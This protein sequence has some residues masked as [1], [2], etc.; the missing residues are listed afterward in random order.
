MEGVRT[1]QDGQDSQ[2]HPV[3]PVHPVFFSHLR[4]SACIRGSTTPAPPHPC[5]SV[6]ICGSRPGTLAVFSIEWRSSDEHGHTYRHRPR[7]AQ[8][9]TDSP[10]ASNAPHYGEAP[11]PNEAKPGKT[12]LKPMD[13]NTLRGSSGPELEQSS[14]I[15]SGPERRGLAPEPAGRRC[16]CPSQGPVAG[17][18]GTNISLTSMRCFSLGTRRA[19]RQ[20]TSFS[21]RR[22]HRQRR[23]RLR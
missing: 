6:F 22:A 23:V 18:G 1:R 19:A 3:D 7:A 9:S 15:C 21:Q 13:N 2:D 10:Y 4:P 5:P 12:A 16:Q 8:S 17:G 14:I 20:P 11:A